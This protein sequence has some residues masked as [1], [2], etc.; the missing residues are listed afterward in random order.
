MVRNSWT[1]GAGQ[2]SE[3]NSCTE[4]FK[5]RR[6]ILALEQKPPQKQEPTETRSSTNRF[7]QK[8][9]RCHKLKNEVKKTFEELLAKY[10]TK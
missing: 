5:S 6:R 2:T 9:L 10:K 3:P 7:L 8:F 1:D 4:M